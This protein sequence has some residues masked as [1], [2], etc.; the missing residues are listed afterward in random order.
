MTQPFLEERLPVSIKM[1]ATYSDEYAVE[2]NRTSSGVEYRRL[3]HPYPQRIYN[4]G[5]VGKTSELWSAIIALYHR[6]YGMYAGFRVRAVD[7]FTTNSNTS[8]PTATD[9]TATLISA[10]IYQ[11][12]KQ[13]G[14]GATPLSIGLPS[15][16]IFKPVS[17]KVLM[18]V[19]GVSIPTAGFTTDTTT[20]QVTFAANK[21]RSITNI[22]KAAQAIVTV[23]SHTFT[24]SDTVHFSS[25]AGMTQINGMRGAIVS[26]ASTTITVDINTTAFSNYATG[27]TVNTRPQT[28]EAVTCGC[29][30]DIPF[31]FNSRI[32]VSHEASDVRDID[33]VEIIELISL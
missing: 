20:G 9:Q 21:T 6:C 23:G 22:T 17:G 31:R 30:F 12:Q 29:E 7:D 2:I 25:V 18:G 1:G 32:D 3:I 14:A 19:G 24:T 8:A 16:T 28:G 33:N 13:Y 26:T 5:Y 27:G 11:L 15:R 4:I 10:G